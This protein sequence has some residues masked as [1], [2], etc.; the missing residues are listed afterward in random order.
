AKYPII[1]MIVRPILSPCVT[2]G[3]MNKL[4]TE[5]TEPYSKENKKLLKKLDESKQEK[6]NK[7]SDISHNLDNIKEIKEELIQSIKKTD[8]F[9]EVIQEQINEFAGWRMGQK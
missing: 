4:F 1:G 2:V 7:I 9:K 8:Q 6:Q 3:H 5:L